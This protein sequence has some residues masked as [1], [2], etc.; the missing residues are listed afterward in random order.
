MDTF[1]KVVYKVFSLFVFWLTP[2]LGFSQNAYNLKGEVV[3]ADGT[4]FFL[5]YKIGAEKVQETGLSLANKFSIKGSLPEPV[6]CTLSNSA[7]KQIRIFVA[8]NSTMVVAGK[9]DQLFN[10]LITNSKEN[11]LYNTFKNK[12]F[13]LVSDYRKMVKAVNGDLKDKTSNA[14]I[15]LQQRQDSLLAAITKSNPDNVATAMITSDLY[16]T[17]TDRMEVSKYFKLLS[18]RVQQSFYGK[19][20]AGFLKAGKNIAIGNLAPDFALKDTEGR[21]IRLSDY[22]GSYVFV[23]FWASWCG[24][25]RKENPTIVKCYQNYASDSLKFLGV[26]L[27]ADA[28]SWRTAIKTDQLP[29]PQLNDPE[30]TNGIA[31]GLYGIRALPFNFMIDPKGKII[32]LGLRGEALEEKI[33][34]LKG[35]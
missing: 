21:T 22:K 28:T 34:S 14:S 32:A 11:E 20:I 3:A 8:E 26:S 27:D 7:N 23:D 31:A 18:P 10:A 17:R 12:R 24:P 2:L 25:C 29:W 6:I 16:M 33:K 5:T 30:S 13:E 4:E 15:V 19:R 1:F 9:V 35:N